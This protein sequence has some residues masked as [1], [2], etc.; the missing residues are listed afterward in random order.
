M[1]TLEQRIAFS[2]NEING[3]IKMFD[4]GYKM[5]KIL[6]KYQDFS[7]AVI[8]FIKDKGKSIL[9]KWFDVIPYYINELKYNREQIIK[10]QMNNLKNFNRQFISLMLDQIIVEDIP[11]VIQEVKEP[12]IEQFVD[13]YKIKLDKNELHLPNEELSFFNS[14]KQVKKYFDDNGLTSG[15]ICHATGTGKTYCIYLA[16][17][18]NMEK[19]RTNTSCMFIFCYYKTILNQTFYKNKK[20]DYEVFRKFAMKNLINIWNYDIY[21]LTDDDMR[22]NT[23]KNIESI[24][25]NKSNKIFLINPHFVIAENNEKY[26]QLPIPDVIIHDECHSITAPNVYKF[27]K[28]FKQNNSKIIGLTATPIRYVKKQENFDRLGEIYSINNR[29]INVIS[30]YDNITAIINRDILTVEIFWYEVGD[31]EKTQENIDSCINC[32]QSVQRYLPNKKI[33]IWGGTIEHS[34]N[35]FDSLQNKLDFDI[36]KDHSKND[37]E[38]SED[39]E[40]YKPLQEGILVCANKHRE[41]SDIPYLSLIVFADLVETKGELPFIQC[42]GRV[43]RIGYNKTVGYVI[44]H[45]NKNKNGKSCANNIVSKL[46]KYYY[47]FFS[48]IT[49]NNDEDSSHKHI[50]L[51]EDYKDILNKYELIQEQS[52]ILIKLKDGL[53]IKIHTNISNEEF[54]NLT[55]NFRNSVIENIVENQQL[56]ELEILNF[57]YKAFQ[58]NNKD[59]YKIKTDVEYYEKINEFNLEPDPKTK[60]STIWKNWYDYLGIDVSVYPLTKNVWIDECKRLGIKNTEQYYDMIKDMNDMPHMPQEL[61]NIK[62]IN[63]ELQDDEYDCY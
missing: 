34:D 3:I 22:K 12:E 25:K 1:A 2:K 36:Y 31:T 63:I 59:I 41:G 8:N 50:Q 53:H 13:D 33:L 38:H 9:N 48:K 27:L 56:A 32:I 4:S 43:Q 45:Y 60:Y 42:L 47:Q 24:K 35:I 61:Y 58:I 46:I 55:T 20:F 57:E 39:Y 52:V 44:D 28:Y 10:D 37:E 11:P 17:S 26:L 6:E 29:D 19:E 49:Y 23:M 14:Q 5:N 7:P 16:M 21:D 51:I 54:S 15:L 18:Y 40:N 30:T 62:H